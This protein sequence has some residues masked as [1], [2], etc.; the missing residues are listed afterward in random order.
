MVYGMNIKLLGEF[1]NESNLNVDPELCREIAK[2]YETDKTI[3]ISN[4][5]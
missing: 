3:N 5:F 1:F 4:A 2:S